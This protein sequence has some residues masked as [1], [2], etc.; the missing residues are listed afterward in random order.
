LLVDDPLDD[1][2][3]ADGVLSVDNLSADSD[4]RSDDDLAGDALAIMLAGAAAAGDTGLRARVCD[5]SDDDLSVN[6][7]WVWVDNPSDDDDV[8]VDDPSDDLSDNDPRDSFLIG[9]DLFFVLLGVLAF[10]SRS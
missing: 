6:D 7:P 1:N 5:P 10:R 2:P 9:L 8:W 3:L 4:E